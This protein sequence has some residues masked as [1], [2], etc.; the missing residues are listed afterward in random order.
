MEGE[1]GNVSD[2]IEQGTQEQQSNNDE[3]EVAVSPFANFILRKSHGSWR[4]AMIT[5]A[6]VWR[7]CCITLRDDSRWPEEDARRV[8]G[9]FSVGPYSSGLALH[10]HAASVG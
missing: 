2:N 7:V 9:T 5:L 3:D 1:G 10:S 4:M 6:L 8:G